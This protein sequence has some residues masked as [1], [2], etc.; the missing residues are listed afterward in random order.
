MLLA[1]QGGTFLQ[2]PDCVTGSADLLSQL[3]CTLLPLL[4]LL[5]SEAALA[6]CKC[7]SH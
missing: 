1:G 7:M 3:F 4:K 6:E 2:L 5:R